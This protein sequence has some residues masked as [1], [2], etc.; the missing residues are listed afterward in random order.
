MAGKCAAG[1]ATRRPYGPSPG[2]PSAWRAGSLTAR[3]ARN[4][5]I[6]WVIS[7]GCL[8][9]SVP[10]VHGTIKLDMAAGSAVDSPDDG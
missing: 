4:L 9:V 5:L 7:V 10:G 2:S 6:L 1:P 8:M 3:Q